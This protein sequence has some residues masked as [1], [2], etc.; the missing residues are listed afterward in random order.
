MKGAAVARG[1]L[2]SNSESYAALGLPVYS[3]ELP[4]PV[5]DWLN[6]EQGLMQ[7]AW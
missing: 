3:P 7:S 1:G 2:V 6:A 5:R 4:A